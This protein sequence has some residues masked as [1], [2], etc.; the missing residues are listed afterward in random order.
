MLFPDR[1][2]ALVTRIESDKGSN[3]VIAELACDF[4]PMFRNNHEFLDFC[5]VKGIVLLSSPPYTQKLNAVVERPIRTV[6][7]MAIAM[8]R[9]GN[10]PKRFMGCYEV[11][12]QAPESSFQED[13]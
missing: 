1:L 10:V 13:A 12:L 9:H 6:L 5:D 2:R 8:S 7:E 3:R 4:A 11:G